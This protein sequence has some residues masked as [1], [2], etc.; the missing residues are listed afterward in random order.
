MK[1]GNDTLGGLERNAAI[2]ALKAKAR[3]SLNAHERTQLSHLLV[4]RAVECFNAAV[5][6]SLQLPARLAD[7]LQIALADSKNDGVKADLTYGFDGGLKK[8][9]FTHCPLCRKKT[10]RP[11]ESPHF[12]LPN[13]S[14]VNICPA[15]VEEALDGRALVVAIEH[16]IH[17]LTDAREVSPDNKESRH[18]LDQVK[19]TYSQCPDRWKAKAKRSWL[20]R[21][22]QHLN[23]GVLRNPPQL[24]CP[25]SNHSAEL[26]N[27]ACSKASI[28]FEW[29]SRP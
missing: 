25:N 12:P 11:H 16:A 22:L 17:D 15:C 21:V 14:V 29:S 4:A 8:A 10:T 1:N 5:V 26:V 28:S 7:R 13:G 18:Y 20:S 2:D 3:R 6:E 19:K 27:K 24:S 23:C 9:T